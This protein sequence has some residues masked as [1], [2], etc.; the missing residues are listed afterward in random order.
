ME[1]EHCTWRS[2]TQPH[3]E[4][5]SMSDGPEEWGWNVPGAASDV[6]SV[7]AKMHVYQ[8]PCTW[9]VGEGGDNM[10]IGDGYYWLSV[11]LL[12]M[13]WCRTLPGDWGLLVP[14]PLTCTRLSG[15]IERRQDILG[16]LEKAPT[17][18]VQLAQPNHR[19]AEP[20]YHR[21]DNRLC[22]PPQH[23][24]A[25]LQARHD[26][27]ANMLGCTWGNYYFCSTMHDF[28]P[29]NHANCA[30]PLIKF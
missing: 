17:P 5:W 23:S 30:H 3:G 7:T 6:L 28:F 12:P 13:S 24:T 20:H 25:A 10:H 4:D 27:M 1:E 8:C 11:V 15:A 2:C 9:E 18:E 26:K 19:W 21:H 22:S 14:I 29:G 16:T